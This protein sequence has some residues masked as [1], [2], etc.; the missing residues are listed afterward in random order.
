[1]EAKGIFEEETIPM[2]QNI[3]PSSFVA[4][5]GLESSS[6]GYS[7]NNSLNPIANRHSNPKSIDQ[8][9]SLDFINDL[10]LTYQGGGSSP[11]GKEKNV[12]ENG[13]KQD[14]TQPE[15]NQLSFM[16]EFL[17]DSLYNLSYSFLLITRFDSNYPPLDR[18]EIIKDCIKKLHVSYGWILESLE[19]HQ[20]FLRWVS[21]FPPTFAPSRHIETIRKETSKRLFDDFPQFKSVNLSGDYWAP[22]YLV[23]GGNNAISDQLVSAYIKQ[24]RQKYSVLVD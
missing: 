21:S 16:H 22:G 5:D 9:P 12:K 13:Y 8:V 19:I 14:V 11:A 6:I 17:P 3:L 4:N 15:R 18:D 7:V 20:D 2:Q 10:R 1:M 24:N 23:V